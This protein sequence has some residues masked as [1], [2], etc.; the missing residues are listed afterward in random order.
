MNRNLFR[1]EECSHA[2]LVSNAVACLSELPR[3]CHIIRDR[4]FEMLR[5]FELN[6]LL[7]SRRADRH[8]SFRPCLLNT[9]SLLALAY[10]HVE[11][12]RVAIHIFQSLRHRLRTHVSF[13]LCETD[14]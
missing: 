14:L 13:D 6:S 3:V 11:P 1:L 5:D 7:N 4:R 8:Y 2:R 9:K 12:M 10:T